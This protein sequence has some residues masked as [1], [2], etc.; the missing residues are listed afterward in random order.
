[1]LGVASLT[2]CGDKIT[3]GGGGSVV[4][5]VTVSPPSANMNVG[6]KVTFAASVDADAGV[7]NR[8]VTWSSSNPAVATVDATTGA[9]EAKAAGT[10]SIIAKSVA[11]PNVSGAAVVTVAAG[12]PALLGWP[13]LWPIRRANSQCPNF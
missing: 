1:M 8:T 11:D 5:S 9:A 2:A 12:V 6:D 4:H 3:E 10:A 7:T 13:P